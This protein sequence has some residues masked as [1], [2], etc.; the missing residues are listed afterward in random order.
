MQSSV[1]QAFEV[2][3]VSQVANAHGVLGAVQYHKTQ[4]KTDEEASFDYI[5]IRVSDGCGL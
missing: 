3:Q 4:I 1:K 2:I 5:C